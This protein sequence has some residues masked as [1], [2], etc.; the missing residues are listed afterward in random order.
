M[1]D[2]K[3]I[4][5]IVGIVERARRYKIYI[6]D[7]YRIKFNEETP[8]SI[9]D[10]EF[11]FKEDAITLSRVH[12]RYGEGRALCYSVLGMLKKTVGVNFT[13]NSGMSILWG[14]ILYLSK[15]DCI[16]MRIKILRKDGE[17]EFI[18]MI[19]YIYV[20]VYGKAGY[21]LSNGRYRTIC[22]SDYKDDFVY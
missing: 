1:K 14:I 11:K 7:K 3:R 13:A 22:Y 10:E 21:R 6:D 17:Y 2:G 5:G 19:A 16:F 8:D 12:E 20:I 15:H 9:N 4:I 18:T